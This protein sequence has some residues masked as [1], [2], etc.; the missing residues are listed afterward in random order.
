MHVSISGGMVRICNQIYTHDWTSNK[1]FH[2][3]ADTRLDSL[4]VLKITAINGIF[5][6]KIKRLVCY[7]HTGNGN[8]MTYTVWHYVKMVLWV[9]KEPLGPQE[10]S[11][12]YQITYRNMLGGKTWKILWHIFS[13]VFFR[14][15]FVYFRCNFRIVNGKG[16]LWEYR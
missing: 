1:N 10:C 14:I 9:L 6:N 11:Q 16:K 2:K 4:D 3:D 8:P 15:S 12:L 7:W 5:W 13:F